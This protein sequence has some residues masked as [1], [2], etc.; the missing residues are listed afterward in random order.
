ML[1]L[2]LVVCVVAAACKGDKPSP[3]KQAAAGP[4]APA[5]VAS[6]CGKAV[7]KGPI[8]WFED[9]YAAALACAKE[10][11]KP[12]VIDMWA[13]WC[14][15]C[16]SMQ[17]TVFMDPSFKP[18]ADKYV[19][20]AMDTDREENAAAVGKL[21]RSAMPTFYVIGPDEAVLSRFV[22]AAT[23]AQFKEFL[24]AGSRALIG[25]TDAGDAHLVTAQR[26]LAKGDLESAEAELVAALETAPT[27]WVRRQEAIWSLQMTKQR[28]G[29]TKGCVDVSE[30]YMPQVGQTAIATNFWASAFECAGELAK[31]DKGEA[32]RTAKLREDAVKRLAAV[33]DDKDAPLSVDD[34]VE[35][36]GYLRDAQDELGK[37]SEAKASAERAKKIVDEATASAKTPFEKMTFIWPRADIYVY[38]G[39]PLDL[40]A[41][42]E[43]LAA[44]LPKE[45]DPPARLGWLYLKAG[46]L[47]EAA[48]WT[49]KAIALAY[50]PRKARVLTQRADIAAAAGDKENEKKYRAEVVKLWESLP[51][52]QKSAD[53]LARA[54]AALA[55]AD[56]PAPTSNH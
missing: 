56:T 32:A 30:Q 22:G 41:D 52:G 13:P 25:G 33:L 6:T 47:P 36:L 10:Q 5:P 28:R 44:Q 31:A 14:H 48:T 26:A 34:R 51:E 15:T 3:Q 20:L 45:Y 12:L 53:S 46:K 54:K 43:A 4:P 11:K 42:Y 9:D 24:D 49:D 23:V 17:T 21:S 39:K 2:A 7:A 19:W 16:I 50:G 1:R 40:V 29:D 8:S 18:L 35:A 55:A 38:L 27:A 37:K